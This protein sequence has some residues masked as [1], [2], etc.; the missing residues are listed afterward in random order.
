MNHI[1]VIARSSRLSQL[2][3]EEV[4]AQFP[5]LDYDLRLLSSYGDKHK[6]ISLLNGE[7]PA[8]IFTRELD[9]E[10]ISCRADI[11]VHSAKDLPYP[12]DKRLE[13]V[14]LFPAFD[15]TDSLVSR[16]HLKFHELPSGSTIG[17]SS[18]LR[19]AGLKSLRSDLTIVGIRGTIEERVEQVCTGKIDA[20]IVATCALRRLGMEHEISEILPFATHP[21]QGYLAITARKGSGLLR[22]LFSQHSILDRQGTVTLLGFGPGNPDLL[23]VA[24]VKAMDHADIIY[25]DDLTD[26][27]YISRLSAEK[28][29]VGK[30]SGAHHAEQNDINRLMLNSA[31]KGK[32]VVR[33]KGGDPMLFA[34]AGEEIAYLESNL[35]QV[36][37]IPGITTASALAA[38]AKVSLTHRLLS[39]SV[40]Y[41]SGH[42]ELP[43]T[44]NADTLVY[45]M[46]A[47]HLQTIAQQLM[48]EGRPADM[49]VLLGY[50]VSG[51]DEQLYDT[52]IGELAAEQKDY[53]T[54]LIALVG[55][56]AG[57][58]RHQ[59]E[60]IKRTLYTGT[61]CPDK[62]MLHTPMI[63]IHP[64]ED[65]RMLDAS[66]AKLA[67]YDY[68]LFTSRYAV[69][70]WFEAFHRLK[71]R[72]DDINMVKVVAIGDT[73]A[74]A[75]RKEGIQDILLPDVDDS[76]GVMTLFDHL[77]RG[78]VLMPRS[79][80][81]LS[82]IPDGLTERGFSVTTVTVYDNRC[83]AHIVKTDL[84]RVKKIIFTSPSTVDNFIQVYGS[85][86]NHIRYRSRGR[87][88]EE[89]IK[90]KLAEQ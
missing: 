15:T 32:N 50:H 26:Q 81:A 8:D 61:V 72:V 24:A 59:A 64:L 9:E 27:E 12:M 60:E 67:D 41:V 47:A 79:R 43:I 42:A 37:V 70:Y 54:P 69:K 57:M 34:H 21:L 63:E 19:K 86:P 5:E 89:Y 46:G 74:E 62:N 10:I 88:T 40:A 48:A 39:S 17:T 58:R 75:L 31:R 14:A 22:Q 56:V 83:P 38:S 80:L 45:Y 44:P 1:K 65:T 87:V 35:I 28:V 76:Y 6:K 68:L 33:V 90:Q 3:V 7:A 23:T 49:A 25:Y 30:R 53:P 29:Y 66:I 4:F 84:R 71:K 16:A 36:Q 77:S 13:V 2:Q 55:D 52:T 78:K 82:L 51:N 73:T 18:P 11:A 20:A 85:L